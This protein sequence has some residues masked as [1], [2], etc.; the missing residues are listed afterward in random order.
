MKK[1]T[2]I[3]FN[4]IDGSGKTTISKSFKNALEKLDI[5]CKYYWC[6]WRGF[7]SWAFKPMISLIKKTSKIGDSSLESNKISTLNRKIPAFSY[8]AILDY[9]L[10]VLPNILLSLYRY[11]IVI[12]DRYIYDVIVGFSV[13]NK[14]NEKFVFK[15]L[16]FLFPK[17]DIS[18][19]IEVPDDIAFS[20][21]DDVPSIEYLTKQKIVYSKY[22]KESTAKI[23]DGTKTKD[24]ILNI[25]MNEVVRNG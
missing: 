4:G 25:V 2:L 1:A 19:L 24:E 15:T 11:E 14:Q 8:F 10:R 9:I 6:G 12:A 16:T 17:P 7:E 20:R 18:F 3:C 5:S 22:L 21:K 23:I 13:F